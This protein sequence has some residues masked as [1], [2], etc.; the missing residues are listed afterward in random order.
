MYLVMSHDMSF[1][2][3]KDSHN[4]IIILCSNI[5]E[6]WKKLKA[7]PFIARARPTLNLLNVLAGHAHTA[8]PVIRNAKQCKEAIFS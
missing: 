2:L 5:P 4:N 7:I 3:L 8:T 6:C 1:L